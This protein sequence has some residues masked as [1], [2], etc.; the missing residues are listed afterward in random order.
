M[1]ADLMQALP[2]P[3]AMVCMPVPS[4]GFS[5]AKNQQFQLFFFLK[6]APRVQNMETSTMLM[7]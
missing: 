5:K 4:N 7:T 3:A 2:H 1:P 6:S